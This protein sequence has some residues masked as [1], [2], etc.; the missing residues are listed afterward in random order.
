[1]SSR[2]SGHQED[3]LW[4]LRGLQ[5]RPGVALLITPGRNSCWSRQAPPTGPL[6]D[7]QAPLRAQVTRGPWL[8]QASIFL[9]KRS[10]HTD[11]M[12]TSLQWL[13][14]S[15]F[16]PM[17]PSGTPWPQTRGASRDRKDRGEGSE[18][19]GVRRRGWVRGSD[20]E[21]GLRATGRLGDASRNIHFGGKRA[22][23]ASC[24]SDPSPY[25]LGAC[26]PLCL[27]SLLLTPS[28]LGAQALLT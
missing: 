1:M 7:R 12:T 15:Q 27:S 26:P 4:A 22:F 24:A 20:G 18:T 14:R 16:L 13:G 8:A 11:A 6:P 17:C 9:Q 2:P 25:P 5:D 21:A 10:S 28:S 3:D 23:G 19:L